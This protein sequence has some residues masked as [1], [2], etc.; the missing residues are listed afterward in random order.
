MQVPKTNAYLAR[1]TKLATDQ[2][3][4]STE[5]MTVEQMKER[6]ARLELKVDVLTEAL[7]IIKKDPGI[8]MAMNN[9]EKSQLVDALKN[10]YPLSL[11]LKE[12]SLSSSGCVSVSVSRS[13]D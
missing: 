3:S 11:L 13:V 5:A 1:D 2:Q 12:V 8:A 4:Q 6:L 7:N 9:A 10:K